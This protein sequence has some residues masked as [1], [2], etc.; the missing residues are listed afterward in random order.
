MTERYLCLKCPLL[1]WQ[2]KKNI[3]GKRK[4]GWRSSKR[5]RYSRSLWALQTSNYTQDCIFLESQLWKHYH[6]KCVTKYVLTG[7]RP[8]HVFL[9]QPWPENKTSKFLSWDDG[10]IETAGCSYS[11]TDTERSWMRNHTGTLLFLVKYKSW[12]RPLLSAFMHPLEACQNC[13]HYHTRLTLIWT[14]DP[15]LRPALTPLTSA[16][17]STF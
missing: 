1:H 7:K 17:L 10:L 14:S 11:F 16:K 15:D 12:N 8:L 6:L 2:T 5:T 9:K 4:G 3:E 13:H